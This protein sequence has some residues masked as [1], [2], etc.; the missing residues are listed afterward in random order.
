MILLGHLIYIIIYIIMSGLSFL[1][2]W[3]LRLQTLW[4]QEDVP[5]REQL[6]QTLNGGVPS[7]LPAPDCRL[8][9]SFCSA[10]VLKC[11][12]R[13]LQQGQDLFFPLAA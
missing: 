12:S 10:A 8:W 11:E 9:C 4:L 3:S 2:W 13:T 6:P 5:T 1:I 7:P